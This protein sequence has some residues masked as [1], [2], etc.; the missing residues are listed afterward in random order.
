MREQWADPRLREQ[1]LFAAR[2]TETEPSLLGFSPHL[3]AAATRP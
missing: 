1:I 2:V 3:I